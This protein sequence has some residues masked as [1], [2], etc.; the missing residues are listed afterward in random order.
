MSDVRALRTKEDGQKSR[1]RRIS[2]SEE[3]P[4]TQDALTWSVAKRRW[5]EIFISRK[6]GT[7]KM[8]LE[9]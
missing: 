8:E 3:T 1:D 4:V 6:K 5:I 9:V 7:E 2:S